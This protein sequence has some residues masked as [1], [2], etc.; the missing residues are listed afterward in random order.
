MVEVVATAGVAR[1][2]RIFV[3]AGSAG[4][5]KAVVAGAGILDD[6][7]QGL[8]G[9]GEVLAVETGLRVGDAA[10]GAGDG[11]VDFLAGASGLFLL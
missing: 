9:L 11:A 10:E 2:S 4:E 3:V 6:F 7:Y 1:I 8:H 5:E